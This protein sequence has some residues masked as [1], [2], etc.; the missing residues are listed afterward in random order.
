MVTSE[1]KTGVGKTTLSAKM[2]QAYLGT[3]TTP[4][5]LLMTMTAESSGW[6][7]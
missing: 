2:K 6:D 4:A 5:T 7:N 1:S 3:P